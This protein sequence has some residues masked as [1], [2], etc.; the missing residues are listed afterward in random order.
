MN[1]G[2]HLG[3]QDPCWLAR[4]IKAVQFPDSLF[5]SSLFI[6]R[7]LFE[8]KQCGNGFIIWRPGWHVL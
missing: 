6:A 7:Y 5:R 2:F 8:C 3:A 1:E 4:K